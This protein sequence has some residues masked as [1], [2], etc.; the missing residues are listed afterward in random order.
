M[1]KKDVANKVRR[2]RK[3]GDIPPVYPNGWFEIIC[4]DE[5]RVGDVKAVSMIG[6]HFAVFRGENGK[7]CVMDAFCPHLGA[8]LGVGGRVKGNCIEC[9]FHGWTYD[10]ETGKCVRIPY[11]SK[12]PSMA[13]TKVW[14]SVELNGLV[15]VWFD[16]EDRDPY[17]F[18][19][20]HP[21]ISSGKCTFKCR[22]TQYINCHTE[23]Q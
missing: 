19:E 2:R 13:K 22:S 15:F 6:L 9:P 8:N 5:L 17:F 1:S 12:I 23:V 20:E 21:D 4:S 11:T 18:L 10:G 16:A 3:I 14:P 7:A